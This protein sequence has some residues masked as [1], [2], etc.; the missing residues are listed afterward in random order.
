[1]LYS[2]I[3]LNH[4]AL[5]HHRKG[6]AHNTFPANA[7]YDYAFWV[8][9]DF[10]GTHIDGYNKVTG[11]LDQD[12]I[13]ANVDFAADPQD[14][15]FSSFGYS[16]DYDPSFRYCAGDSTSIKEVPNYTN[17]FLPQCNLQGGASGGPWLTGIDASGVGTVMSLNSWGFID[18]PG[19]AGPSLQTSSGS[20]AECL[21]NVARTY[22]DPG[23]TMG[24]IISC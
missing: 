15:H 6:W 24:Y 14:L 20:R 22:Q 1:M 7:E 3:F 4:F 23:S 2:F 16:E 19:M 17:L 21:F 8:V 10:V 13:P 11:F 12:V 9:H 5:S 18:D